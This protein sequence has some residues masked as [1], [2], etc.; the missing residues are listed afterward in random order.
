V[1]SVNGRGEK[2]TV[3]GAPLEVEV[4][5][6]NGVEAPAKV[7]DNND[8]TY[9]VEYQ[10][11]DPGQHKIDVVVKSSVK[12]YYDHIKDSPFSVP[13]KPGTDA[14]KS[15]VHG[16]G[17]KEA[18]DTLPANFHIQAKDRDGNNIPE[19]GDPFEVQ[20]TGP[21]GPVPVDLKD[22]GDGTYDITY[23]PTV[24]GPHDIDVKLRGKPV[25]GGPFKLD[26]KQGADHEHS[27]VETY[28]FVIRAKTKTGEHKKTG[29]DNFTVTIT[30]PN[31]LL[32]DVTVKDLGDGSYVTYYSITERGEYTISVRVNGY[33]IKGSPWKQAHD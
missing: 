2:M 21:S 1:Q 12:I 20:V 33:D 8:G 11:Q 13:I 27:I 5:G 23:H 7:T 26:V 16:P 4:F 31:G 24:H 29:G 14:A 30:G 32:N 18:Y 9:S 10:A 17:L 28:S 6:P 3:G 22:N 25:G 15:Q 19:G